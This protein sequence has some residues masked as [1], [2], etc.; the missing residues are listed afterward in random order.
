MCCAC[1]EQ[2]GS[3]KIWN[4][5][6]EEISQKWGSIDEF[7]PLHIIVDDGNLEDDHIASCRKFN[8]ERKNDEGVSYEENV[9]FLDLLQ[10][11][12]VEERNS[13]YGVVLKCWAPVS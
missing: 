9:E 8:E 2:M 7:G 1:Y 4:P 6:V 12:T 11:A 10:S 13:A 5:K 3:H